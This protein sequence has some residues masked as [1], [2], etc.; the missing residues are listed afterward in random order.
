MV[1]E[2][3]LPG[4]GW[5]DILIKLDERLSKCDPDY[6]IVQ[7]KEKFGSLRFYYHSD[8]PVDDRRLMDM[9][10]QAAE[11][12]SYIICEFCGDKGSLRT[13]LMW[14]KTLCDR[15]YVKK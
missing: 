11:V 6:R 2:A 4:P 1:G 14:K 9:Y 15:C 12:K 7:I 3:F 8:K 5:D 10:V 13:E